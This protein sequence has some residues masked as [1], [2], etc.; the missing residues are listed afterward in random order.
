VFVRGRET[1]RAEASWPGVRDAAAYDLRISRLENAGAVLLSHATTTSTSTPLSSLSPG[2]YTVT[3]TAI[4]KT[5]MPGFPSDTK[6]IR[7]AGLEVPEGA[8]VTDDGAIV[9][10]KEQRVR[11]LGA[12]G[13]EVGYGTSRIF[14]A[15]PSSLGL[16]QNESV[17]ARLRL[18]G[19][20]DE[21]VIRLEPR[22]LR[23]RVSI[24]PRAAL[25]PNDRVSVTV[26]FYDARGRVVPE[27]AE[28][29]PTVTVNLKPVKLEW[30]RSGRSLRA[31]LPP[32]T[33]PGPWVVRA[34]V[35]DGRG[36]LLGRDFLEVAKK[37][38]DRDGVAQR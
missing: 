29:K 30:Q 11:L 4:D 21:T 24:D 26:D 25:W 31:T 18:P 7:V 14:G 38:A 1:G 16:A 9:L 12:E 6:A 33:M 17:V 13:L 36:E 20:T 37:Q 5:G 19:A 10:S 27:N 23:A 28:V 15:A 8:V 32:P 35:R 2:T 22:G 3:V 34:E